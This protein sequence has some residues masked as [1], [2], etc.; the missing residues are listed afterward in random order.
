MVIFSSMIPFYSLFI[1]FTTVLWS[2]SACEVVPQSAKVTIC[3]DH[4]LAVS[5]KPSRYCTTYFKSERDELWMKSQ[6]GGES[7]VI[8]WNYWTCWVTVR[9]RLMFVCVK[10]FA[11][12]V[13]LIADI[14]YYCAVMILISD[15]LCWW[16]CQGV[17]IL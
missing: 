11:A 1:Q 6:R 9:L 12:T 4:G 7:V 17:N 8:G 15:E 5:L 13:C 3:F 16:L 14:E 10:P 2:E